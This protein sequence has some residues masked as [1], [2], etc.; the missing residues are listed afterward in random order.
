MFKTI[1]WLA[2][3]MVLVG[4][5]DI[6]PEKATYFT[7]TD[8]LVLARWYMRPCIIFILSLLNFARQFG[9]GYSAPSLFVFQL[10][11]FQVWKNK[12]KNIDILLTIDTDFYTKFKVAHEYC[13]QFTIKRKADRLVIFQ[14]VLYGA[15]VTAAETQKWLDEKIAFKN[16]SSPRTIL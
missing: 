2:Q 11:G 13:K 7:D 4:S 15:T 8:Y 5:R 14:K 12:D 10:K 1:R 3:D 16:Q 6:C 9:G